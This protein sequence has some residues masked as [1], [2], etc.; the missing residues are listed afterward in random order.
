MPQLSDRVLSR[1]RRLPAVLALA[2]LV[3]ACGSKQQTTPQETTAAPAATPAAGQPPTSG[4]TG[5]ASV[6]GSVTFDGQVP[7]LEATNMD[8]DPSC[9]AK[10]AGPVPNGALVLGDGNHLGNVFVYVKDGLPANAT[11]A[12][13]S[14]PAVV[15]QRGCLYAPRVVGVMVGQ[16]VQFL[17]SD[18]LLHNVHGRPQVN[19][20]FNL[21]MP[22]QVKE[23]Q[24]Q[25][26]QAEG[27]FRIRCDVHPWMVG[28]LG[29]SKHPFF[30]V[31]GKDGQFTLKGLPAGTYTVEAWHEKL[32][33]Q[34][35]Q[36]TLTDGG[37]ATVSF[38]FKTPAAS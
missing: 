14:T 22:A 12:P 20:E 2:F 32:G 15:D 30:A 1:Q 29:V 23:R 33:T 36:V 21:A 17:N 16:P 28:Y 31:T 11:G 38:S 24:T 19:D 25:F 9:A 4:P 5:S 34:D 18:D 6:S 10:H 35:Q 27:M 13:P 3:A 8:G 26:A 7:N 37:T